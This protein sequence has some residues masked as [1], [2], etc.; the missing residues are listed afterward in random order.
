[1]DPV[2]DPE[3]RKDRKTITRPYYGSKAFDPSCRPNGGCPWCEGNRRHASRKR[4]LDALQQLV[5]E[6]QELGIYGA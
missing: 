2:F 3:R 6:A 1:M 4:E 5:D